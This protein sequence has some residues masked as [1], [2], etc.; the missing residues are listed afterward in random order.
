MSR[1]SIFADLLFPANRLDKLSQIEF[2]K[3]HEAT[4]RKD[5]QDQN[6]LKVSIIKANIHVQ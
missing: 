5:F 3:T 4:A 6:L 2:G 1:D